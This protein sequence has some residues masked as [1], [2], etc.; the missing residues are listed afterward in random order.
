M[1]GRRNSFPPYPMNSNS[2]QT[3]STGA[4]LAL[5]IRG[6]VQGVGFRPFVY[7]LATELHLTGW[8]L[9]SSQGVFVEVEGAP[10]AL[11][12]FRRRLQDESPAQSQIQTV[13]ATD[14]RR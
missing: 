7:R 5:T 6:V 13:L 4:R 11:A 14:C 9:N 12:Q 2:A 8:V 10:D 1:Y 3:I